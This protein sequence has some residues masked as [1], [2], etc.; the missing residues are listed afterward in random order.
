MKRDSLEYRIR[1]RAEL[2]EFMGAELEDLI[3]RE[4]KQRADQIA[5]QV[6]YLH[7]ARS[8]VSAGDIRGKQ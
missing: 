6:I 4:A 3:E 5:A 1:R 8:R 7:V 2:T